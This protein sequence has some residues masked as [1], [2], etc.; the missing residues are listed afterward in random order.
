[1]SKRR[2]EDV[3]ERKN[4]KEEKDDRED[5]STALIKSARMLKIRTFT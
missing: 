4:E 2:K 1:M 3:V 5:K